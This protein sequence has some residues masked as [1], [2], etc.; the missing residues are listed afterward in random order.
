M[1]FFFTPPQNPLFFPFSLHESERAS[2]RCIAPPSARIFF[3]FD[4][5]QPFF[6]SSTRLSIPLVRLGAVLT[7]L[8]SPDAPFSTH[9]FSVLVNECRRYGLPL[10]R[11]LSY[12]KRHFPP[13]PI[14]VFLSN[15]P[16]PYPRQRH[17]PFYYAVDAKPEP[18][19]T[20]I[21]S[22]QKPPSTLPAPPRR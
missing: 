8:S 2:F 21:P 20:R 12:R 7:L 16:L 19:G 15:R 9:S 4:E 6:L 10:L 11:F 14:Q 3:F 5:T 13:Q 22:W 1:I 17:H 18:R